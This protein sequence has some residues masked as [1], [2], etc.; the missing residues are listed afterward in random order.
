M[1]IKQEID[2]NKTSI[3]FSKN[4]TINETV[5]NN[6]TNNNP[7]QYNNQRQMKIHYFDYNINI[8]KIIKNVK[9]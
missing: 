8:I 4:I 6:N 7:I 1:I 2:L 5:I 9:C 3:E